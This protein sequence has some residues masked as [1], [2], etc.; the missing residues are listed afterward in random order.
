MKHGAWADFGRVPERMRALTGSTVY[1]Q[2][3]SCT[4]T[5]NCRLDSGILAW[6]PRAK[7]RSVNHGYAT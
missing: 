6:D 7:F 4:T 1:L 2:G 3:A 5:R